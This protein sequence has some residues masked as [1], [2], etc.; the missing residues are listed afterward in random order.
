M[1]NT[2]HISI[3]RFAGK[4][5]FDRRRCRWDDNIK[6]GELSD[7]LSQHERHLIENIPEDL[8]ILGRFG[9]LIG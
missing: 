3:T 7:Y 6:V 8:T 5:L 1:R 4:R 2:P 9:V